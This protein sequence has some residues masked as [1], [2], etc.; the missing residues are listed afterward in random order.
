LWVATDAIPNG[1]LYR[2]SRIRTVDVA[3]GLSGT[4]FVGEVCLDERRGTW[5]GIWA[6][7][8]R[9]DEFGVWIGGV[10]WAIDEGPFKLN[11]PV[12]SAFCS[13]HPGVVGVLLGDG[14][15]RFI[16]DEVDPRVPAAMASRAGGE[17]VPDE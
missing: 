6:G 5:G 3:D 11:G 9:A 2:N 7:A 8:N 16:G 1:V 14:S 4:V 13:P 17:V 15:V 12:R 10:F